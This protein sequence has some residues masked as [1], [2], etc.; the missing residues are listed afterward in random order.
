MPP[1]PPKRSSFSVSALQSVLACLWILPCSSL[2]DDTTLPLPVTS[3]DVTTNGQL[4]IVASQTGVRVMSLPDLEVQQ[5]IP[6]PAV[7]IHDAKFSPDNSHVVVT[8]GNP[9]EH[10][11]VACYTWPIL[12]R[13]W[14]KTFAEDTSYAAAWSPDGRRLAVGGHDGFICLLNPANGDIVTQLAGHSGSV[15][16]LAFLGETLLIS[17]GTD[18]SLRLWDVSSAQ[19]LRLLNNHT[20]PVT[21]IAVHTSPDQ[22]PIVVSCGEDK[23]LRVWQP[24]IGRLVR[25]V[26]LPSTAN[27]AAID[28][29]AMISFVG[30]RDGTVLAIDLLQL[31]QRQISSTADVWVTDLAVTS[32][33]HLIT[34]NNAGAVNVFKTLDGEASSTDLP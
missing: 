30:C 13:V 34:G 3:I 2:A 5:S 4:A 19:Q 7:T 21:A 12:K 26:K 1:S 33:Q 8:G 20:A 14:L 11:T 28:D 16:D 15:L 24:T 31:N 10:T 22:L 17:G 23:T 29:P 32:Q 9:G 25:F 27:C 6:W 18:H